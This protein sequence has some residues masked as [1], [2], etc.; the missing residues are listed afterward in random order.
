MAQTDISSHNKSVKGSTIRS[1]CRYKRVFDDIRSSTLESNIHPGIINFPGL[2]KAVIKVFLFAQVV[3]LRKSTR[4]ASM[5]STYCKLS[6]QL[7]TSSP[8]Y[9]QSMKG[10][11]F[12][13]SIDIHTLRT[14]IIP[15]LLH[16]HLLLPTIQSLPFPRMTSIHR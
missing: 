14:P 1:M 13:C 2:S 9:E 4:L 7:P 16:L 8:F 11:K 15:P 3:L 6:A 5:W 10:P 12:T